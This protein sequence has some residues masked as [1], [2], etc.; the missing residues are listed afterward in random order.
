MNAF[1]RFYL[2][3]A[4]IF[5]VF[6]LFWLLIVSKKMYQHFIGGLMGET[7]IV[8]AILFYL[9]YI[10]GV[11]FF[12]IVPGVEKGSLVYVLGSG[13]LLGLICYATYD[14]TN[15]ATLKDW[16]VMM[17]VIDLIWGMFVTAAASGIT[18]WLNILLFGGNT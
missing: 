18:Y 12:V 14:L 5:L 11:V 16:P 3:C 4:G 6:D 13:A 1:I 9:I 8:P 10:A 17:T 7:K 15:L 2:L